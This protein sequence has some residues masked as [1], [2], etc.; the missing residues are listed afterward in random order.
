ML[1]GCEAG[2]NGNPHGIARRILRLMAAR[3]KLWYL[4][5]FRL[6]DAMTEPQRRMVEK[7]TRML[8]V[9]RGQRIYHD[10]RPRRSDLEGTNS[11]LNCEASHSFDTSALP[12]LPSRCVMK[13]R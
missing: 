2:H 1:A 7:M 6:L 4:Q 5:R 3:S 12:T 13:H 10:G 9:K 8:E 11:R